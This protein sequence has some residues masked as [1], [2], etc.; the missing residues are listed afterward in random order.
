MSGMDRFGI[1]NDITTIITNDLSVNIR[2]IGLSS[3]DGI[4]EG[5][6]DLYVHNKKDLNNL[7]IN[8]SKI[9]GVESVKRLENV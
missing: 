4:W 3:H 9:K 7:L 1:Y 8:L 5:T 6:I 2:N